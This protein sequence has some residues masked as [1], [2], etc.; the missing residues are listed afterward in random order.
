MKKSIIKKRLIIILI[1]II[2]V[3]STCIYTYKIDKNM[4]YK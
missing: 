3:I 1:L 4:N 2:A